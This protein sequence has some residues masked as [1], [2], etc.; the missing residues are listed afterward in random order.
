MHCLFKPCSIVKKNSK[1]I[2]I[3]FNT[4][5]ATHGYPKVR[6]LFTDSAVPSS[7]SPHPV[8]KKI[9]PD[10]LELLK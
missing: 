2:N 4:E 1:D 7:P 6:I 3:F 9:L 8:N 5:Y 10:S